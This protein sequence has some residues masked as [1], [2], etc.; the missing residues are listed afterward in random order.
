[1]QSFS[2]RQFLKA[3]AGGSSH[4]FHYWRQFHC[5][6]YQGYLKHHFVALGGPSQFSIP[7]DPQERLDKA[8]VGILFHKLCE[9]YY[10]RTLS[11]LVIEYEGET[12]PEEWTVASEL[13]RFYREKFAD[14]EWTV[15]AAEVRFELTREQAETLFGLPAYT[16][17]I[18]IP[19]VITRQQIDQIRLTRKVMLLNPGRYIIDHKVKW[20]RSSVAAIEW[21]YNVQ[22][23]A[24][25]LSWDAIRPDSPCQGAIVN[26]VYPRV[27][28]G[29]L[30]P[31]F[32]S[33]YI[34]P[35]NDE[36]KAQIKHYFE[37]A[38]HKRDLFGLGANPEECFRYMGRPCQFHPRAGGGCDLIGLPWRTPE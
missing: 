13:F 10:D 1:M 25:M 30:A 22:M 5:C 6:A 28:K 38:R 34:P 27:R 29:Q 9:H 33:F 11:Q 8:G 31:E 15:N 3:H 16:G 21:E 7:S 35:P 24:Y 37:S 12:E 20:Q 36:R 23:G 17:I 32:E 14:I 2:P 18:D 26:V 19:V 4:G